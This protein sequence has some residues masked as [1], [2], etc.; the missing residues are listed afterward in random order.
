MS[1]PSRIIDPQQIETSIMMLKQY[2]RE[3]DIAPLIDVLES[4]A[5]DPLNEALL[6]QL[7]DVFG[8]LGLQQGV[9]LTYAPYLST[10]LSDGLF[11]DT[12]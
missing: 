8:R 6:D 11:D 7:S 2:V 10:L 1:D 9:V 3:D 5:V 12:D 4:M